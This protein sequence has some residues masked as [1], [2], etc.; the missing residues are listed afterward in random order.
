MRTHFGGIWIL[1][2]GSCADCRTQPSGPTGLISC[3]VRVITA[4]Y[5]GKFS[6]TTRTVWFGLARMPAEAALPPQPPPP[7]A[8]RLLSCD[9][10]EVTEDVGE[11]ES[12]MSQS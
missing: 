4:K 9:G 2:L 1:A 12:R 5:C 10:D 6:V 7:P 8:A 3:L 11:N